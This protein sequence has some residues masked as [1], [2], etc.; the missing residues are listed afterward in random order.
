[1]AKDIARNGS[2]TIRLCV[3]VRRSWIRIRFPLRRLSQ[4][5]LR[6]HQSCP[7]NA[8]GV[9][10]YSS[11]RQAPRPPPLDR[12]FLEYSFDFHVLIKPLSSCERVTRFLRKLSFS[13]VVLHR[14]P[15]WT[16]PSSRKRLLGHRLDF[17][18]PGRQI[19]RRRP[20]NARPGYLSPSLLAL[21]RAPENPARFYKIVSP[22]LFAI[23]REIR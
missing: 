21:S 6:C 16:L 13:T 2:S 23:G 22:L 10:L 8:N 15:C 14:R 17:P 7:P 1:M 5:L 20:A 19:V 12:V 4:I 18:C 11:K 3:R 9:R